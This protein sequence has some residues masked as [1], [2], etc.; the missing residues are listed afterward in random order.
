MVRLSGEGRGYEGGGAGGGGPVAD[1]AV[2]EFDEPPCPVGSPGQVGGH[3][4]QP[5]RADE[6]AER[7]QVQVWRRL[8]AGRVGVRV[9]SRQAPPVHQVRT[10]AEEN[11]SN[12]RMT[13]PPA[14]SSSRSSRNRTAILH[15]AA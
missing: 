15:A 1:L 6:R 11:R 4:R 13:K 8:V 2:A 12:R 7:R 14:K 3:E 9:M 10:S 5:E